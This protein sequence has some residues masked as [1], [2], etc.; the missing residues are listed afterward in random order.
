MIR[1][2]F[3]RTINAF[4]NTA[5]GT[6]L[7]DNKSGFM[8]CR[9]EV[10]EHILTHRYGYRY[11][12]S[13]VGVAALA[14]GYHV[15]EVDTAFDLRQRGASFLPRLPVLPSGRILWELLKFRIETLLPEGK[16]TRVHVDTIAQAASITPARPQVI[17]GRSK[18]TVA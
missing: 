4:L 9:R 6:S 17:E 2:T 13:F 10:L 8:L 7:R 1:V 14:R 11:F 3:S 16:A 18:R 5:F 15:I 12:Q